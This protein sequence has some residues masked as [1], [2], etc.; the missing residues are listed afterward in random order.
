MPE[1]NHFT[2]LATYLK[3]PTKYKPWALS[4]T[5]FDWLCFQLLYKTDRLPEKRNYRSHYFMTLYYHSLI[6]KKYDLLF[7]YLKDLIHLIQINNHDACSL[8]FHC[9]KKDD[10]FRRNIPTHVYRVV[11]AYSK[12]NTM[13]AFH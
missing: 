1:E 3:N 2:L 5:P 9:C 4:M 6:L 8:L 11:L 7:F 12:Q 10:Y 13:N